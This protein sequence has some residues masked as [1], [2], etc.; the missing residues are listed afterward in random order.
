MAGQNT[1]T[2]LNTMFKYVQ[3]KEQSLLPENAVL[4]KLI[5]E[6]TESTT[7]G[8]GSYLVP[9]QLTFEN[10]I[11]F[12]DG[13]VFALNA[14]SAAV[15][16]EIQVPAQ[17]M[18]LVTEI[19]ES[20]ANRMSNDK[21]T[22]I[23][24]AT[25]R[26]DVM[27]NSIARFYEIAMLYGGGGLGGTGLGTT[28]TTSTASGTTGNVILSTASWAAGIWAG[29][30]G[31]SIQFYSASTLVSTG[32]DSIFT[33]TAVANSTTSFSIS[34]TATGI[35]ALSTAFAGALSVYW[36]GAFANEMLGLDAQVIGGTAF[37]NINPTTYPL[38]QGQS[39]SC[40]SASLNMSKVLSGAGQAVAVGG[41]NSEAV[42]MVSAATY[43]NLNADQSALRGYDQ[44][45]SSDEAENGSAAI[46]Y[47]GPNGKISVMVNNITK[48]GEAHLLPKKYLKRVGAKEIS[49][50]R[51]GKDDDFFQEKPGYAGYTLRAG[52]EF[53][54]LLEKPAQACKFTSIVNS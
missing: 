7:L 16:S 38:W 19:S 43:A 49:F 9:V 3:D 21:K 50:K 14:A 27:M 42:L 13:T 10:G 18:V 36:N 34:G 8:R 15:Y 53:A 39:V 26:A 54:V 6:I 29:A 17:P 32:A 1:L 47:V 37:F 28:L 23:T 45:Y 30:V 12:G 5:P 25:L 33:I 20:V 41:L 31:A 2:S 24:E 51:P 22:F 40:G 44:S 4:M 46:T 35:T 11:T 48:Q 52:G